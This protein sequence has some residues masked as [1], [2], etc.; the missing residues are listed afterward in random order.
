[1]GTTLI[2]LDELLTICPKNLYLNIEIKNIPVIYYGIEKILLDCLKKHNRMH[3]V[4]ISSFDH[5]ALAN[6]QTLA[7]DIELGM[8][9]YYRMLA[10]WNYATD[11][12]LRITS[13]HPNQLYVDQTFVQACKQQGYRVYPFTV[14]TEERYRELIS[15]GVDGVFSNNPG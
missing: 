2:T 13:I 12:G 9:F 1:K 10:P 14:N 7:P 15:F 4:L 3:R 6:V 5:V 11:S 8:L